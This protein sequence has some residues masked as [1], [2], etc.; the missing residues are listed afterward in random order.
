MSKR[1]REDDDDER[2]AKSS[3]VSDG[4][5]GTMS[6]SE[7][8]ALRGRRDA[9]SSDASDTSDSDVSDSDSDDGGKG[10]GGESAAGSVS[11]DEEGGDAGT[12]EMSS[13]EG[14]TRERQI[15]L[16]VFHRFMKRARD[17]LDA[18]NMREDL[19]AR[20]SLVQGATLDDVHAKRDE[21]LGVITR[22]RRD[23]QTLNLVDSI[24]DEASRSR[25]KQLNVAWNLVLSMSMMAR[26]MVVLAIVSASGSAPVPLD[27]LEGVSTPAIAEGGD[28]EDEDEAKRS[29]VEFLYNRIVSTAHMQGMRRF[30]KDYMMVE[31]TQGGQRTYAYQ[32]QCEMQEWVWSCVNVNLHHDLWRVFIKQSRKFEADL[33]NLLRKAHNDLLPDIR[34]NRNMVS[35]RD[36]VV[37]TVTCE[38]YDSESA[39]A[40]LGHDA[41]RRFIPVTLGPGTLAQHPDDVSTPNLDRVMELQKFFGDR[42]MMEEAEFDFGRAKL[43]IHEKAA[44][45]SE[46]KAEEVKEK[47]RLIEKIRGNLVL[48]RKQMDLD[49][50]AL[51]TGRM[52]LGEAN[53][54]HTEFLSG[55]NGEEKHMEA[56][57]VKWMELKVEYPDDMP[58]LRCDFCEEIYDT[59]DI[60]PRVKDMRR[61][62]GDRLDSKGDWIVGKE[63]WVGHTAD[64]RDCAEHNMYGRRIMAF[65]GRNN[66]GVGQLDNMQKAFV[67]KGEAGT[68]KT[69]LIEVVCMWFL[70]EQIG[71]LES[72]ADEKWWSTNIVGKWVVVIGELCTGS[73][74]PMGS[75][76]KVIEGS[77][78]AARKRNE[79][80]KQ[81][82]IDAHI[83]AA[84]NDFDLPS[85]RGSG[86]RRFEAALFTQVPEVVD[87]S[88]LYL[89]RT[90]TGPNFVR[91]LLE[92]HVMRGYMKLTP[93]GTPQGFNGLRHQQMWVRARCDLDVS[94]DTFRAFLADPA[95]EVAFD[96]SSYVPISGLMNLYRTWCSRHQKKM[97]DVHT[98]DAAW[99]VCGLEVSRGPETREWPIEPAENGDAPLL[100][101][102]FVTGLRAL[103]PDRM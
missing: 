54:K 100:E 55:D 32:V 41:C 9:G 22:L 18:S 1:R 46:A 53:A 44:A 24:T 4:F 77:M 34:L 29:P 19:F 15:F 2:D 50:I 6:V 67:M 10:G 91:C 80:E 65:L 92:Y 59:A 31:I 101:G 79:H 33:T 28:E 52:S 37:N 96:T 62:F 86:T 82:K 68:G 17:P 20:M 39:S 3:R 88:L 47:F 23:G 97:R 89:L 27:K 94:L 58:R 74:I 99:E 85:K 48:L 35:F 84:T 102:V 98:D 38:Q 71:I 13:V 76:N 63:P 56:M 60:R 26:G 7:S 51:S 61:N 25:Q 73:K 78:I 83:L 5:G 8:T 95:S 40:I 36:C 30:N 72:D 42:T 14:G 12:R 57:G 93:G 66:F 45:V 103:D 87:E 49:M 11:G 16:D 75:V 70:M 64:P 69:M 90:E 81:T 43:V 21:M